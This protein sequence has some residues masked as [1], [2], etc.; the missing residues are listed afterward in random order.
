MSHILGELLGNTE[1]G[2]SMMVRRLEEASG[3]PSV[4][5]RLAA[6]ILLCS[7]QKHQQ[8]KLDF[9]DTSG[10]ELYES[11]SIL[12]AKHDQLLNQALGTPRHAGA[13]DVIEAVQQ[14]IKKKAM[15]K[16]CWAIKDTIVRRL[17]K[18]LPPKN[19]MR[20]LGYRSVDSMLKRENPAELLAATMFLESDIWRSKFVSKYKALHSSD[21]ESREIEVLLLLQK[22]WGESATSFATSHRRNM[23][24]LKE[25]GVVAFLPVNAQSL[26][27]LGMALLA[28]ALYFIEQIMIF[29]LYC[30]MYQVKANFGT[31]LARGVSKD[32]YSDINLEGNVISWSVLK[33]HLADRPTTVSELLEPHVQVSDLA[34]SPVSELIGAFA[35]GMDF[36]KGTEYLGA[37]SADGV[38]SYNVLDVCLNYCNNVPYHK[39]IVFFMRESLR[40]QLY[41]RYLAQPN[42]EQMVLERLESDITVSVSPGNQRSTHN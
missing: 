8:L 37:A 12:I 16:R 38:V 19:I 26:A 39:R 9:K 22:K 3:R 31:L 42:L 41:T 13:N 7:K 11:L 1:P 24:V 5:V 40:D 28:Q 18:S 6:D 25:L 4:D 17:L 27:G 32:A 36:W 30:K 34:W 2:F 23:I 21:F 35:P 10:E 29:S 15:P 14:A 33:R 20:Q